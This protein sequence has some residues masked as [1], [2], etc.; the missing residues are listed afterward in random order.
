MK[1]ILNYSFDIECY[2]NENGDNNPEVYRGT[3]TID[4][5]YTVNVDSRDIRDYF[6]YCVGKNTFKTWSQEKQDGF[7]CAIDMIYREDIIASECLEEDEYFM[8]WLKETYKEDAFLECQSMYG[9]K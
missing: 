4:F 6:I 3:T 2:V 7:L 9:D 8:E 1:I 5:S